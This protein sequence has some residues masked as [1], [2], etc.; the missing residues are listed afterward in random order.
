MVID[1]PNFA[2][3]YIIL[4]LLFIIYAIISITQIRKYIKI[5]QGSEKKDYLPLTYGVTF[6]FVALGRVFLVIFDIITDFNVINY[7]ET[8]FWIW[9]IGSALQLFG[10]GLWFLMMEK[11]VLKGKDKYLLVIL[12][13]SF[14][15]IGLIMTEVVLASNLVI[16]GMLFVAYIPAAYVYIAIQSDGS[17]RKKALLMFFGFIILILGSL[18][19][20]EVIIAPLNE[21]TGI[22]RIQVHD[23]AFFVMITGIILLYIGTK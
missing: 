11:R 6:I 16:I 17:V 5:N 1:I 18:L 2:I 4:S 12:Y 9:K 23:I 3:Y 8:N 13:T 14:I 22:L 21:M 19:P 15:V 20:S 7:N 10:V